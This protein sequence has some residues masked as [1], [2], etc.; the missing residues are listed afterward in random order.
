MSDLEMLYSRITVPQS[1]QPSPSVIV[2]PAQ[3][4]PLHHPPPPSASVLTRTI[5]PLSISNPP[6]RPTPGPARSLGFI[7]S[8]SKICFEGPKVL[9]HGCVSTVSRSVGLFSIKVG[10]RIVLV[11]FESIIFGPSKET[12][13]PELLGS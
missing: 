10:L 6:P 9:S 1:I 8:G 7:D 13:S 11:F 12:M 3:W 5:D 4:A 2:L